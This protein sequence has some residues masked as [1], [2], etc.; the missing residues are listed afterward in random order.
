M[1]LTLSEENEVLALRMTLEYAER[2]W[3]NANR[4]T[5]PQ[6]MAEIESDK[7]RL[8]KL[9]RRADGTAKAILD[10]SVYDESDQHRGG[11]G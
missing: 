2:R 8:R 9:L 5:M 10:P 3:P 1:G 7:E 4:V 6:L 11:N